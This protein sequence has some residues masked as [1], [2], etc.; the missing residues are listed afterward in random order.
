MIF[1]A[2]RPVSR[3]AIAFLGCIGGMSVLGWAQ[4]P[5]PIAPLWDYREAHSLTFH[6]GVGVLAVGGFDGG[7]TL[8][9]TEAYD[10]IADAWNPRASLPAPRQDHTAHPTE[11]GV[12]IIGGW[13]GT[14]NYPT[15]LMR[16][17]ADVDGWTPGPSLP[18]GRA[19][20]ASCAMPFGRILITGGYDGTSDQAGTFWFNTLNNTL[21]AGPDLNIARSSHALVALYDGSAVAIGGFNPDA[22]YQLASC[23][24]YD[25]I[26]LAWQPI[27]DL[28]WAADHLA[29]VAIDGGAGP[30][31]VVLGGRVY[32]PE[33]NLFEGTPQ[34]AWYDVANDVWWGFGLQNGHSYHGAFAYNTG[35]F[36]TLIVSG[37]ADETGF[38]V[39]T[40]YAP[41]E[42][43]IWDGASQS[44]VGTDVLPDFPGRFRAASTTW[45]SGGSTWGMVCGGDADGLGT[46]WIIDLTPIGSTA[47]PGLPSAAQPPL[48][49]FPNPAIDRVILPQL[50][51]TTPWTARDPQGKAVAR[52]QGPAVPVAGWTPGTYTIHPETGGFARIQVVPSPRP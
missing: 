49:A 15:E 26:S 19:G 6:P 46:G 52:G 2:L 30:G 4:T 5:S 25:P 29:A 13:D 1:N 8:S 22:G 39:T 31:I 11:D 42:S 34:G 40:T 35:W 38:N 51:A 27:A 43:V 3:G 44:A 20:H 47:S 48:T 37:G 32:N 23:E 10:P 18:S 16:Y 45:T 28:P 17:S 24:R 12:V 50:T 36:S 14:S 41:F 33:L 21:E 9:S 7:M